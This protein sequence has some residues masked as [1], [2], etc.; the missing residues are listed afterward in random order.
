MTVESRPATLTARRADE[1]RLAIALAARDIFLAAGS[2]SATVERI[3]EAVGIAPRTF[4]RHFPVKED[5]VLPLFRRFGSL[6]L[7]VLAEADVD[8]DAVEIL[9]E[10]FGTEVPRRGRM[11]ADR[12]F[13][14]LVIGDPQYRLRWLD[15]GQDLVEPITTFLE[16]SYD[17][18]IEPCVR[19]LPAQLIVQA[20]R[21]AYEDWAA[22]GDFAR[23]RTTLSSAMRMIIGSLKPH[24]AH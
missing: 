21:Y 11:D 24:C 2:T 12:S 4:H 23:M 8:G 14:A 15:W 5:V 20:C 16:R 3:C 18:E 13:L 22:H 6:S 10:A 9:V 1:L 17:L 19:Q 7:Q